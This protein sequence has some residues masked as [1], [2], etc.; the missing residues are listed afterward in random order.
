MLQSIDGT[1]ILRGEGLKVK[2]RFEVSK[3]RSGVNVNPVK[4][5]QRATKRDALTMLSNKN[6]AFVLLPVL[7]CFGGGLNAQETITSITGDLSGLFHSATGS[8]AYETLSLTGNTP[9]G[10]ERYFVTDETYTGNLVFCHADVSPFRLTFWAILSWT[11]VEG[12]GNYWTVTAAVT[13]TSGGELLA[14]AASLSPDPQQQKRKKLCIRVKYRDAKGREHEVELEYETVKTP[15]LGSISIGAGVWD[16]EAGKASPIG[17]TGHIYRKSE[18]EKKYS[19]GN[20]N[21]PSQPI[22]VSLPPA[23]DYTAVATG[24][25]SYSNVSMCSVPLKSGPEEFAVGANTAGSICFLFIIHKGIKGRVMEE[26]SVGNEKK[27]V[28]LPG[29]QVWIFPGAL[30][31]GPWYSGDDGYFEIPASTIDNILAKRGSSTY[32]VK[33]IPPPRSGPRNP[34]PKPEEISREVK[35]TKCERKNHADPCP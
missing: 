32:I 9:D 29:A 11:W 7:F 6:F 18:P 12:G 8:F 16:V 14:F 1:V 24:R 10:A 33:V 22:V 28:P 30:D 17:V 2:G 26:T 15:P 13:A 19:F 34:K 23:D 31:Y 4:K 20:M 5:P 25:S 35:L 3:D 21:D 27:L